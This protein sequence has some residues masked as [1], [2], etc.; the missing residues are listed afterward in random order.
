MS[1]S[2][3]FPLLCVCVCVR[4]LFLGF[5]CWWAGKEMA[6]RLGFCMELDVLIISGV[7]NGKNNGEK[8]GFVGS[9]SVF[10]DSFCGSWGS[11]WRK[12]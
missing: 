10:L 1:S 11:K 7:E 9:F 4:A 3:F 5:G 6:G 2:V 8:C 12:V